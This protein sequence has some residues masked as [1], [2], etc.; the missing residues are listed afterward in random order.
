MSTQYTKEYY[1]KHKD[2]ILASNKTYREKHK[3]ERS[4]KMRE[5]YKKT[6]AQRIEYQKSYYQKHKDKVRDYAKVHGTQ[7]REKN[8]EKLCEISA[9]YRNENKEKIRTY[10]R[11]WYSRGGR[12]RA[13]NYIEKIMEWRKEHPD[14][15]KIHRK[16][17]Y[18]IRCGRIVRPSICSKCG[19]S[20][21]VGAHHYNYEHFMNFVWLCYSCHKLEHNKNNLTSA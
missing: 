4:E 1:Q 10:Y 6:K 7:Y 8:R 14:R 13:D 15:T 20:R 12:V 21:R 18:E 19:L 2:K 9:K 17:N 3:K 11:E 5:Y 16:I